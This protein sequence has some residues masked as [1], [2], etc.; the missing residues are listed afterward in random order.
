MLDALHSRI[1]NENTNGIILSFPSTRLLTPQHVAAAGDV[2]IRTVF[3]WGPQNL[4]RQA[5]LDR[6][7]GRVNTESQYDKSNDRVFAMYGRP[8]FDA[9][10]VDTFHGG[11]RLSPAAII[12]RIRPIIA[13]NTIL[14]R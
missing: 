12:H 3:L 13:A 1:S 6:E 11:S 5:A 2:G 10:R 8:E 14:D 9:V 4:C 7:D